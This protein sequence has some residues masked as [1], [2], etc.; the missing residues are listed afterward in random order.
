MEWQ[1]GIVLMETITTD[2][3]GVLNI[4]WAVTVRRTSHSCTKALRTDTDK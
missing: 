1:Q 4:G 2:E 3:E